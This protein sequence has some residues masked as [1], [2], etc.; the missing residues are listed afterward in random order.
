MKQLV[1]RMAALAMINSP[2]LADGHKYTC[3]MHPEIIR[4]EPGQCPI[5]GM[6]LVAIPMK[7]DEDPQNDF[8]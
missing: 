4:D 3:P 7:P 6:D 8:S 5:C 2:A 1:I